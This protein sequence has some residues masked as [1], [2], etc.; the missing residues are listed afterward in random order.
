VGQLSE[1]SD[2]LIHRDG[3]LFQ[4]LKLFLL[5][6]NHS[7]G[8]MMCR[9]SSSKFRPVDALGFLMGF[10][11]SIPSV[12]CRTKELVR[13]WQHL[14]TIVALHHLH[15]LLNGLE[16]TINIHQLHNMRKGRRLSA[17]KISKPIP[18]RRWRRLR[19]NSLHVDHGLLHSLKYLCLHG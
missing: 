5:Q 8:N 7:L 13:G 16:S 9:E 2:V 18:R 17:V 11:V 19:L 10:H 4:I 6:L 12:D 15:L 1:L 3:P 14:L